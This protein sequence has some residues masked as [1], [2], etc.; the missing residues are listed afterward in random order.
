MSDLEPIQM[1]ITAFVV[2]AANFLVLG[3][4]LRSRMEIAEVT[5]LVDDPAKK[6]HARHK[7]RVPLIGGVAFVA[8]FF[9][10]IAVLTAALALVGGVVLPSGIRVSFLAFLL[11]IG[12][13]PSSEHLA[14][15][16]A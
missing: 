11:F 10:T 2:L 5:G 3:L 14:Q 9:V 1:G 6:A 12:L 4:I 8:T 7:G 15:I 16:A 13:C